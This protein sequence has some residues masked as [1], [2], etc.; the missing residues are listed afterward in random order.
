MARALAVAKGSSADERKAKALLEVAAAE[1][2]VY[3]EYTEA[4]AR[5]A[6]CRAAY[7]VLDKRASI[8]Q[9]LLKAHTQENFRQV[10]QPQWSGRDA[11]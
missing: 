11:A 6:A 2:E 1:D 7:N 8:G 5:D 4:E 10:P 3:S 9:S